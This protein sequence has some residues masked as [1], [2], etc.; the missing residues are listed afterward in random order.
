MSTL[1]NDLRFALRT[2]RRSPSF[3]I[4]AMLALGLGTGS[5]A[6]V[7]S[8]LRGV[9]LRPLPY[10]QPDRLV[11]LWETNHVKALEHEPISPV[12][13]GDYRAL[14][15]VFSDAAAWWRPQIN[16]TD[17]AGE[18]IRVNA[19]ETTENLFSVLGVRPMIGSDFTI[20]PKLYGAE[21]QTIIS[22]RL[23]QSR[24]AGDRSIIGKVVHLN[25]SNYTVVGVMPPGF[26]YPGE[27]DLWQQ[28][29]W[30]LSHHT[31]FAHFMESVARLKPGVSVE[32]AQ[33]ELNRTHGPTWQPR[34][35]RRTATGTCAPSPSI[36]RWPDCFVRRSSRCSARRGCCSSSR[37]STS[38][39]CCWRV[40]SRAVVRS[41]FAPRSAR[42][43]RDCSDSS[44]PK[45]SF[46]RRSAHCS[47]S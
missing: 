10:A 4:A 34:T 16:L 13:F 5:A 37:A 9:V 20:H 1:W 30:D 32:S 44:S 22:H 21:S 28:L 35:R 3:T 38:P 6:G 15:D 14:T 25:G 33:R 47:A 24:F 8:L 36:E 26:N 23:W 29:N 40:P 45:A 42:V 11:M 12:N 17:D 19:I 2:L 18:P 39:I 46:W 43:V 27:T 31:R 41:R 7:F